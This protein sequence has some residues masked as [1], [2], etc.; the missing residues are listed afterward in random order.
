MIRQDSLTTAAKVLCAAKSQENYR[1]ICA[2]RLKAARTR[3]ESQC[4]HLAPRDAI[5]SRGARGLQ[6]YC[7]YVYHIIIIAGFKCYS[8]RAG[9]SWHVWFEERSRGRDSAEE[10]VF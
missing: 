2:F 6:P 1:W 7:L 5:S 4:R 8:S 10:S 9:D 3:G